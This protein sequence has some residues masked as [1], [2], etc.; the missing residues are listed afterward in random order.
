MTVIMGTVGWRVV[1][2]LEVYFAV[3]RTLPSDQA[4]VALPGSDTWEISLVGRFRLGD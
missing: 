3:T 4:R 2:P 1:K